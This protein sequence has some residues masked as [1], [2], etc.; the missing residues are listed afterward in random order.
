MCSWAREERAI[1]RRC[2]FAE[3]PHF[4]WP[5]YGV[6]TQF[7][8]SLSP[9]VL[10]IYSRT[11]CVIIF[12]LSSRLGSNRIAARDHRAQHGRRAQQQEERQAVMSDKMKQYRSKEDETMAQFRALAEARFGSGAPK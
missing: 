9:S 5:A 3:F 7:S 2:E 8:L 6:L 12:S 11:P 10:T 4:V 1:S